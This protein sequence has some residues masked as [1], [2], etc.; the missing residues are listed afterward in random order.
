MFGVPFGACTSWG[1]CALSESRYVRP[2][3]LGKWKSGRGSTLGVPSCAGL[4][5]FVWAWAR[6]TLQWLEASHPSRTATRIVA[7]VR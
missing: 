3:L 1:N 5:T 6:T 4:S 7:A 2:M